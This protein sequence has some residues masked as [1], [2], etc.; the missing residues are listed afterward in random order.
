MGTV[1]NALEKLNQTQENKHTRM[2][3][4]KSQ[5]LT[6]LD[7]KE[8]IKNNYDKNLQLFKENIDPGKCIRD[9]YIFPEEY[10]IKT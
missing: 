5:K 9:G 8:K 4:F 1:F 6:K 7:N 10:Q 3:H 2:G